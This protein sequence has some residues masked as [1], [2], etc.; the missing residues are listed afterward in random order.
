VLFRQIAFVL[1]GEI[2]A[3]VDRVFERLTA[4]FQNGDRVSV[5]NL[6]KISGN[7]TLQA[8]N[9][10]FINAFGKE[11]H[12]VCALFENGFEDV[13]Q[14]R[15][16]QTCHI[17][18]VSKGDF[19]LQHPELRQVAA[20]V[21]VFRTEGWAKGVDFGQRAGVGFAVQLAGNG[22]ERLFAEEVFI[23]IDFALFVARQV[24][25]IQR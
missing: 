21:G 12:V 15:F 6:G 13:L 4:V 22:Q 7:E 10:V 8:V 20:G 11:L 25:Q 3:P 5:I 18:Q 2:H 19:R 9:S 24:F 14:H 1:G 23:E 17:V 16:R